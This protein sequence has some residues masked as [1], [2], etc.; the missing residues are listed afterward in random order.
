MK[1]RHVIACVCIVS[2]CISL[3]LLEQNEVK[4]VQAMNLYITFIQ[5]ARKW[6]SVRDE[7]LPS[8]WRRPQGPKKIAHCINHALAK[9]RF[10]MVSL[11]TTDVSAL[12]TQSA[13]KLAKS[14]R[15]WFT[16]DQLD[17]VLMLT[18]GFGVANERP[19]DFI[20]DTD[21]LYKAGWSIVCHV[22]VIN[23]PRAPADSRFHVAKLYSKLNVWGLREYDALLY[24]DLDTLMI[25]ESSRLFT[26]HY[27]DMLQNGFEVGAVRD[28]PSIYEHNFNAGVLMIIPR[29]PLDELVADIQHVA[30]PLSWAEQGLLNA[31]Y[32]D[33]MYEL[34][35]NYNANL[36]SKL[37]EPQIWNKYSHKLNIVH[38]TVSKGWESIRHLWQIPDALR[39]SACWEYDTDAFCRLWDRM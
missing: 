38:Y 10:A 1:T 21:Q 26:K 9:T 5:D 12:Y 17:L 28:R 2:A 16:A 8:F 22:P 15:A 33:V 6:Q 29:R 31:L 24:M 19:V 18:D 20:F 3:I 11:L 13:V 14:V 35:Y 30:H 37:M 23:H 36:V 39:A 7:S 27:P 4:R 25:R 32:R 34:P